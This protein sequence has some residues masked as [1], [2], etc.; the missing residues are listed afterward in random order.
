MNRGRG[1]RL[2]SSSKKRTTSYTRRRVSP[3]PSMDA[4]APDPDLGPDDLVCRPDRC[5]AVRHPRTFYVSV[6]C[7]KRKRPGKHFVG[8][9]E[10]VQR[11]PLTV[12]WAV[13]AA[14]PAALPH[15]S[16]SDARRRLDPLRVRR[17]ALGVPRTA[18]LE[19]D[20]GQASKRGSAPML[21]ITAWS[22]SAPACS[23]PG[24]WGRP[25]RANVSTC[26]TSWRTC[27]RRRWR[28]SCW[29][30]T[31]GTSATSCSGP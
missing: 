28:R 7:P 9:D 23:G 6:H 8:F 14:V 3:R 29:S 11:L 13:E 1:G 10:A 24:G 30:V 12:W 16:R 25:R 22:A 20:L 5:R 15:L 17:H 26:S 18:Q 27:H 2:G 21:W 19:E 31:P 4:A